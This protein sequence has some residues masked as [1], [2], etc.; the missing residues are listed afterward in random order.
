M[1]RRRAVASSASGSQAH[2][3]GRRRTRED[4]AHRW[5]RRENSLEASGLRYHWSAMRA[6]SSTPNLLPNAPLPES[7]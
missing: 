6:P 4:P 5:R 2:S 3:N 7:D 1:L